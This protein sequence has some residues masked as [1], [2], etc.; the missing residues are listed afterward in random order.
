[1]QRLPKTARRTSVE[2]LEDKLPAM[3]SFSLTTFGCKVNQYESQAL[4]E[5]FLGRGLEE[6]P[7]HEGADLTLVNT[8]IV[9]KTSE[10]K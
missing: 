3:G 5:Y 6:V 10:K 8:C 2:S 1:M 4:R 7:P 9:T